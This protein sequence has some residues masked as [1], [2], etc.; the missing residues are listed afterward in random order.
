MNKSKDL[1]DLASRPRMFN[2]RWSIVHSPKGFTLVEMLVVVAIIGMLAALITAAGQGAYRSAKRA[3]IRMEMSQIEMAL[4]RYK[5]EFGEYPPELHDND[6]VLR[7]V[8][9]RWPRFTLANNSAADVRNAAKYVYGGNVD[10]TLGSASLGSLAFWL[11]GFRNS[12]GK[13]DGF[14]ADPEAPFGRDIDGKINNG[15]AITK[16]ITLGAKD[17]KTFMELELG[18]NVFAVKVGTTELPCL[19][20]KLQSDLYV[21]YV[22]FRGKSEGGPDAYL[23]S[24]GTNKKVRNFTFSAYDNWSGLGLAVPYARAGNPFG[25]SGAQSDVVWHNPDSYQLIHP[26]LDG[27][28]GDAAATGKTTPFSSNEFKSINVSADE[29]GIGQADLDN[30][31]NF[32]ETTIEALLP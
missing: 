21:P 11:G 25:A 18:R 22:Y 4:E 26:G 28:F 10:Y 23:Y 3:K 12:D 9:K 20:H 16:A 5:N 24:D 6:S 31:T 17:K 8:R 19:V 29:N 1:P 32:T 13:F 2:F 14:A 30:I 27:K 15:Q 7:H